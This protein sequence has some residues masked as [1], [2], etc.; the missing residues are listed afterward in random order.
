LKTSG[1]TASF[2]AVRPPFNFHLAEFDEQGSV[3][4][5]RSSQESEIW[6]N[7]GYFVFRNRIFDYIR[8]GEELVFEP[9]NRLIAANQLLAYKHEGF[10]RAMDTLRDKQV[11][12]DIVERGTMPWALEGRSNGKPAP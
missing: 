7:G 6:I 5:M 4:R 9:F 2:V 10:W 3:R 12:E 1:K 11:L 8:E